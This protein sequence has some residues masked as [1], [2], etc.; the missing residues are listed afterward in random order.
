MN[1]LETAC[2]HELIRVYSGHL[3]LKPFALSNVVERTKIKH[4]LSQLAY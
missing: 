1:I 2:S 3:Y 4:P